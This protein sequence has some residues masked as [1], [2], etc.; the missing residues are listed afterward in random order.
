MVQNS[1]TQSVTGMLLV[2]SGSHNEQFSTLL[3]L[4]AFLG[5][6][7]ETASIALFQA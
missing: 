2:T 5:G 1:C 4:K 3:I 7:I 6:Q